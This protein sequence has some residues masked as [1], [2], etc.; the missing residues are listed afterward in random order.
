MDM[1]AASAPRAMPLNFSVRTSYRL[2]CSLAFLI[3]SLASL[4]PPNSTAIRVFRA[5][6]VP[7]RSDRISSESWFNGTPKDKAPSVSLFDTSRI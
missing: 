6:A 4:A 1:A 2:P 7:F 3:A 5:V